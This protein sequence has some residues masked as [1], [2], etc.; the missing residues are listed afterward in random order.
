MITLHIGQS[1]TLLA[2]QSVQVLSEQRE[3]LASYDAQKEY[4]D[5]PPLQ[6]LRTG[7]Q[8]PSPS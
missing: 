7:P 1:H 6:L 4:N 8:Q 2:V 3:K 5:D